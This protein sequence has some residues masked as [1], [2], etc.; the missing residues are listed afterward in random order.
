[1]TLSALTLAL[2]LVLEQLRGSVPVRSEWTEKTKRTAPSRPTLAPLQGFPA[3]PSERRSAMSFF[4]RNAFDDG[5][6]IALR[7]SN[8]KRAQRNWPRAWNRAAPSDRVYIAFALG[9]LAAIEKVRRR[10]EA[11]GYA[12]TLYIPGRKG[13][14]SNALEVGP[15]YRNAGHR[16]VLDST[17]ARSR[18]GVRIEQQ[19]A[20]RDGCCRT[21]YSLNGTLAGC[22]ETTCGAACDRARGVPR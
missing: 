4:R 20:R 2:V 1:M 13:R 21:C 12:C 18:R 14:W 6:L 22:E 11:K 15:Y 17:T 8:P 5:A 3:R 19:A 16:L 10:L 7:T 9:D